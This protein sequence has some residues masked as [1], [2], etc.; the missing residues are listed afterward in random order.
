[1]SSVM[2]TFLRASRVCV[3]AYEGDVL[4]INRR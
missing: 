1:M 2:G 4:L 3:A